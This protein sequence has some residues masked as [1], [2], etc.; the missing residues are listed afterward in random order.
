MSDSKGPD[1]GHFDPVSGL[2]GGFIRASYEADSRGMRAGWT[3]PKG[4]E[5]WRPHGQR[6]VTVLRRGRLG[7]NP[8]GLYGNRRPT[9][10]PRQP[11]GQL[12]RGEGGEVGPRSAAAGISGNLSLEFDWMVI[13]IYLRHWFVVKL[14]DRIE[15]CDSCPGATAVLSLLWEQRSESA[16]GGQG[17][18]AGGDGADGETRLD[19]WVRVE[20]HRLHHIQNKV[21]L[22]KNYKTALEQTD[23]L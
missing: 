2:R 7:W 6:R 5:T 4:K 19:N 23:A 1:S 3:R 15:R 11:R 10:P 9:P 14:G 16:G 8:E 22:S 13:S 12:T 18:H 21:K 20:E 17:V